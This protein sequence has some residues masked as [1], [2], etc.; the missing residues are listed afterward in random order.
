VRG[1]ALRRLL[2]E[3]VIERYAV[4]HGIAL[5]PADR[6]QAA[7]ETS[8]LLAQDTTAAQ[9]L[10]EHKIN[11][12]FIT[13]LLDHEMLVRKVEA[14][15]SRGVARTGESLH[16]RQFHIP[17]IAGIDDA[18]EYLQAVNLATDGKPVPPGSSVRTSWVATFHLPSDVLN[19]LT[20]AAPRQFVGPFPYKSYYLDVQF[21]GRGTHLYGRPARLILKARRF[22]DW[23]KAEVLHADPRCFDSAGR[24]QRCPPA[25]H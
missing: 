1:Q 16:L 22:R 24:D 4:S 13:V 6:V 7:R 3:K 10:A 25:N 19:A 17:R 2:E 5:S 9:L 23:L 18:R 14:F 15:V 8:D 21:L 20:P 12:T 11:R